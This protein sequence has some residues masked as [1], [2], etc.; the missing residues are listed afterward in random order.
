MGVPWW[1]AL[2][3]LSELLK[4]VGNYVVVKKKHLK[5]KK[6]LGLLKKSMETRKA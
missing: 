4:S 5:R 2:V 1:K 3:L 6:D